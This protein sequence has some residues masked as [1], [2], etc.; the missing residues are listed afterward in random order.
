MSND[1]TMGVGQAHELE[2]AMNRVGKWDAALVKQLSTG[3]NLAWVRNVLKG[4]W[5]AKE[6][7]H[8]IDCCADPFLPEGW[9]VEEHQKGVPIKWTESLVTLYIADDQKDGKWM[10]GDVLREVLKSQRVLNAN[11]LD[12]LLKH[13]ELIPEEWK[14]QRVYFWGT[15][16]RDSDGDLYVR[17]LCWYGDGWFW[18]Y[19]WLGVDWGV[20][21]PAAVLASSHCGLGHC[22]LN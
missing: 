13:P 18:R 22:V 7:N 15:I 5:E 16:Y 3:D 9:K 6:A 17:F 12:F 4:I 2:M 11:V 21:Y 19:D 8:V 1:F 14:T 20:S 10:K